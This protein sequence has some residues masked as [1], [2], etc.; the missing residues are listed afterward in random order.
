MSIQLPENLP[1][2]Y[3]LYVPSFVS[4]KETHFNTVENSHR[5]PV[6]NFGRTD[7]HGVCGASSSEFTVHHTESVYEFDVH[8]PAHNHFDDTLER[9]HDEVQAKDATKPLGCLLSGINCRDL[10][11]KTTNIQNSLPAVSRE[12]FS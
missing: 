11:H 10:G 6:C 3:T 9:T 7:A 4:R 12:M 2:H 8:R 1:C 5:Q